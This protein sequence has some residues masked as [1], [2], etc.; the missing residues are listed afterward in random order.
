M[1]DW[2]GAVGR[3]TWAGETDGVPEPE[4][5]V[6]IARRTERSAVGLA[7]EAL[8]P[9]RLMTVVAP[10]GRPRP[11]AGF[12]EGD[13]WD[14][15][16]VR[17]LRL[18]GK[19]S[20]DF[21]AAWERFAAEP[22]LVVL[23]SPDLM[24]SGGSP[25]DGVALRYL[26]ASA[27][28]RSPRTR[29]VA[30]VG[31]ISFI[32]SHGL[33]GTLRLSLSSPPPATTTQRPA[34]ETAEALEALESGRT[35]EALEALA[36]LVKHPAYDPFV[37]PPALVRLLVED[38]A[39]AEWLEGGLTLGLRSAWP[40]KERHVTPDGAGLAE[41]GTSAA[42]YRLLRLAHAGGTRGTLRG[43][44]VGRWL[45]A[46]RSLSYEAARVVTAS[47][48]REDFG[49]MNLAYAP[50]FEYGALDGAD[51]SGVDG[52]RINLADADL[53]GACLVGADLSRGHMK[54]AVL[55]S[56]DLTGADL[57]HA[58]LQL[59][60][61]T[62]AVLKDADLTRTWLDHAIGHESNISPLG[63]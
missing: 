55:R 41:L 25:L 38:K 57:S 48:S 13:M 60:D 49:G 32:V 30:Y 16:P 7:R 59:A 47:L 8:R 40:W 63:V 54:Q 50:S 43:V 18:A 42:V 53:T 61:L 36:R 3:W 4:L 27:L 39:A 37:P 23:D 62:G 52:Y 29:L 6:E 33:P 17:V 24:V 22:G 5:L 2:D 58:S 19:D 21:V 45:C 20:K 10:G 15:E 46:L 44:D 14:G 12:R 34:E 56:A 35:H 31:E 26:L 11:D 1:S 51:L 28:E 9:G